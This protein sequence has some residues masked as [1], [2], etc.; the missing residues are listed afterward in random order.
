MAL[1]AESLIAKLRAE[2]GEIEVLRF[3]GASDEPSAILDECRSFGLLSAHKAVVVRNADEFV[4]GDRRALAERYASSP[5]EGATLILQAETW[6]PGNLDKAIK[7]VGAIK[8]C[9][10]V[11]EAQAMKWA[12]ERAKA[13]HGGSL[14]RDAAE[15]LVART[16]PD[17]GRIDAELGKLVASA[18]EGGTVT[19]ALVAELVELSREQAVW[20]IQGALAGGHAPTAL[21]KLHELM[22]TSGIDPVPMR[23]FCSDVARKVNQYARAR[24]SGMGPG[25]AMKQA[26]MFGDGTREMTDLADSIGSGG[27]SELLKACVEAD[28]RGKTGVG[29]PIRGLEMLTLRFSEARRTLG[30]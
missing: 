13:R 1:H 9:D 2:H 14:A 23:F 4:K 21:N 18:G 12:S 19:R 6:R 26:R 30:R 28:V 20:L 22:D 5:S 17:L 7:A 16:G 11:T 8:P 25:P 24:E 3:D 29:D 15:E 10:A 27:A